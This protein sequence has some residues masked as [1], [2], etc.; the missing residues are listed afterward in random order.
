LDNGVGNWPV[1]VG[2]QM[3]GVIN[4]GDNSDMLLEDSDLIVVYIIAYW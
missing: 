2:S 1:V 4:N 3:K